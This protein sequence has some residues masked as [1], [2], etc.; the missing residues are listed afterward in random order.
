M[1]WVIS[2][3]ATVQKEQWAL[4]AFWLYF[5]PDTDIEMIG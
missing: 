2:G 5:D 4:L 1:M 3:P